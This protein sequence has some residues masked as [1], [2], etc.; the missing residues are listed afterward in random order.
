MK[1][2]TM[3]NEV[4][5]PPATGDKQRNV[6]AVIHI[7][8]WLDDHFAAC[9]LTEERT[10]FHR[11]KRHVTGPAEVWIWRRAQ[12]RHLRVERT[13]ATHDPNAMIRLESLLNGG[14]HIAERIG[15]DHF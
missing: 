10:D 3:Q 2:R 14:A 4:L 6:F 13:R 1:A 9:A 11:P 7:G 15:F 8:H 5:I 12:S